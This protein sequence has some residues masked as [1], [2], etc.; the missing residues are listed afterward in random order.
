MEVLDRAVPASI[1]TIP[2]VLDNLRMPK[3]K[4]VHAWLAKHPRLVFP[5]PPVPCSWRNQ[6][7]PWFSLRQRKRWAIAD[8]A[9]QAEWAAKGHPFLAQWNEKAHP[10]HGSTKS[11]AKVMAQ[12]QAAAKALLGT[13]PLAA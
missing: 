11:V 8:F 1:T 13:M 10:F 7:A 4:P 12:C 3:G 6:V 5:H 2:V 9:A